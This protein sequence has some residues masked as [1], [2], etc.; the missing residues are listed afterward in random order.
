M[1]EVTRESMALAHG[2]IRRIK[3]RW[4]QKDTWHRIKPSWHFAS[5][6]FKGTKNNCPYS[7]T[8]KASMGI[9]AGSWPTVTREIKRDKQRGGPNGFVSSRRKHRHDFQ[10]P[11]KVISLLVFT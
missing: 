3:N 9:K 1:R 6:D 4:I 8:P 5:R 10:M 11:S 2:I 7:Q